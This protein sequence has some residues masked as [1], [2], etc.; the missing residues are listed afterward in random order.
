MA[1][2]EFDNDAW[3]APATRGDLI[4]LGVAIQGV[5]TKLAAAQIAQFGGDNLAS[6]AAMDAY[7]EKFDALMKAVDDLGRVNPDE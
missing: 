6:L 2:N 1:D 4:R 7:F 3:S 5:V